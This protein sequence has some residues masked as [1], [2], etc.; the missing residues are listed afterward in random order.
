MV[1]TSISLD[2]LAIAIGADSE[3]VY[4]ILHWQRKHSIEGM[5]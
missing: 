3:G 2:H 1:L 5:F 4:L